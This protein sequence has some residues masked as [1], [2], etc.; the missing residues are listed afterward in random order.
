MPIDNATLDDM[1]EKVAGG[2]KL[3][4]HVKTEAQSQV[5]TVL[6]STLEQMDVVTDERMAVTEA[7]LAKTREEITELEAKVKALEAKLKQ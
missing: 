4:G 1:A 5:R 6:E 3:L 7:L 2:L